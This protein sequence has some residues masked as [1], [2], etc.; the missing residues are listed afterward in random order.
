VRPLLDAIAHLAT[1]QPA[2]RADLARLVASLGGLGDGTLNATG[3]VATLI[4]R[5]SRHPL[6]AAGPNRQQAAEL[7]ALYSEVRVQ[8][9]AEAIVSALAHL[10]ENTR[11]PAPARRRTR[12]RPATGRLYRLVAR[13]RRWLR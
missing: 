7:G 5:Y 2:D 13:I 12:R 4:E 11:D 1:Y 8:G 10:I 9:E 6:L 3:E